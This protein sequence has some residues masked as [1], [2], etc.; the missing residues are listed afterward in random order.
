MGFQARAELCTTHTTRRPQNRKQA[1]GH[2]AA[3]VGD[4]P[5]GAVFIIFASVTHTP[6]SRAYQNFRFDRFFFKIF[7][8]R[9]LIIFASVTPFTVLR[10]HQNFSFD[11]FFHNFLRCVFHHFCK[12]YTNPRAPPHQNFRFHRFFIKILSVD[13]SPHTHGKILLYV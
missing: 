8:V 6:P 2:W 5:R 10:R 11:R 13:P 9:V 7:G 12:C 1:G 3:A 4:R